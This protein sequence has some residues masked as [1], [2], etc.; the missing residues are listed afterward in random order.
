MINLMPFVRSLRMSQCR[1]S[2]VL[3]C[4]AIV[5][6]KFDVNITNFLSRCG[7]TVVPIGE[8]ADV[9]R[10]KRLLVR[11]VILL[12]FLSHRLHL[13]DRILIVDLFDT[14][15]QGDPF[16]TTFDRS[17]VGLNAESLPIDKKQLWSIDG[18]LQQR[19]A[20]KAFYYKPCMNAGTLTGT[21]SLLVAFL[22]LY[23]R[24]IASLDAH[25]LRAIFY[26]PDQ[27][28]LN[29]MVHTG[30]FQEANIPLHIYT[31]TE[32]FH[33]MWYNFNK[34]GVQY[35]LGEYT[36]MND[37]RFPL[38]LHMFDRSIHFTWSV[39]DAC[40]AEFPT[41]DPYVRIGECRHMKEWVY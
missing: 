24:R 26:V 34:P 8:L 38:C 2:I 22:A 29:V 14:I 4:D 10:N 17:A 6:H 18:L 1:A 28:V 21:P 16:Q 36:L 41:V 23:S 31:Q 27:V 20:R 7:V 32:A 12:D 9:S 40:P 35:K 37:G 15:F 5:I 11:N 25:T 30:K 39:R 33:V 19:G 13:F 3:F